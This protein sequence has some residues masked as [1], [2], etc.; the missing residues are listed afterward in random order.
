MANMIS[1][2]SCY[3]GLSLYYIRLYHILLVT[4]GELSA[5]V[6]AIEELPGTDEEN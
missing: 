2:L 4:V 3:I 6:V 1:S 5:A